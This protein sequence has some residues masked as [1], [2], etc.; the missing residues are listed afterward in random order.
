MSAPR[1]W[2][3]TAEL[4]LIAGLGAAQTVAFVRTGLWPLP[5]LAAAVLAW[6]VGRASSGR[7]ALLGYAYGTAWLCAGTWWLFVSLHRYGGLPAWL[8]VLAVFALASVLSL[9]LAAAMAIVARCRPRRPLAA[10]ALFAGAWLL[11]ELARG[12][13]LTGFPWLASGYAQVDSP[14]GGFAPWVGVYGVGA[15]GAGLAAA[16]GGSR[17][18]QPRA[19]LRPVL[20]LM[21]ALGLGELA[22]RV[23]FTEP[24][25]TLRLTLL[26]G[27]VPQHEKFAP[28]F[29]TQALTQ[30]AA[31]LEAAHGDLVVGPETV[32]PLLPSQLDPAWWQAVLARF[33]EPDR[34][35]ILG[36][37]LGNEVAGYTNS[38]AGISAAA[39]ALPGGF[40]R[41]DKH[42]LVPFGEFIPTGFHWFTRLMNIPLG[43]FNRGSPT[44]PSFVVKGE[45]VA[46]NICYEDLFGEELAA[47]FVAE[48]TAP[49]VLVNISNIGWFGETVAVPQHLQI[50]RMR[51][52]ELQR[53]MV[54]ATNTGVTGVVDHRGVVVAAL[55]PFQRGALETSVQ[56]R[57]GIT[58]FAWWA[59]RFG[60]WPLLVVGL[61]PMAW[62]F[63]RRE[64][65]GVEARVRL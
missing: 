57:T 48:P 6:R 56:G 52:L 3:V 31:Q 2:P 46:P 38:A 19:W 22:G 23:D 26:Q 65:L 25:G 15:I 40:Y 64:R 41:Y 60:L 4:A 54:R 33:R 24:T 59:G 42:H 35:A 5:L 63:A 61:L 18:G 32:I 14:L 43:D 13:I 12:C 36:L 50:S 62:S 55:P 28:R 16:F 34:A 1:R 37:P 21:V 51:T 53:P 44:A 30:T 47:R 11:A 49:T 10:A 58:P 7:A 29:V 8:S 45:R 27:N 9:Y 17:L 39:A 20:A